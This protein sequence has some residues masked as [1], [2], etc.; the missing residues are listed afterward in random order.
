M[1]YLLSEASIM[2]ENTQ[3]AQTLFVYLDSATQE[4]DMIVC[5]LS[6]I[7]WKWKYFTSFFFS[8]TF[9]LLSPHLLGIPMW[10]PLELVTQTNQYVLL[11]VHIH[12]SRMLRQ[13]AGGSFP[14][15]PLQWQPSVLAVGSWCFYSEMAEWFS[16]Y[17]NAY[18]YYNDNYL[19]LAW[20]K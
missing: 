14:A 16:V 8:Y 1:L 5:L 18:G 13:A 3:T 7:L 19:T 9:S 6:N 11:L 2:K 20:H 4:K 10:I 17:H 12:N 15:F